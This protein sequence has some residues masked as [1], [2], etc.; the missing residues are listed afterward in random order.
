MLIE[1]KKTRELLNSTF[2]ASLNSQ[3]IGTS[4]DL[5]QVPKTYAVSTNPLPGIIIL[6]LGILMS[7]HHQTSMVSTMLHKQWGTLFV[8]AALARGVTYIL[9]YLSPPTSLLPSRPP[10]E[11][12]VAFCLISGGLLFMSSN[13][14]MVT[15]LEAHQ[16]NAMFIFTIIMAI[17][18]ALM[19]WT[20]ILLAVK[21]W[22]VRRTTYRCATSNHLA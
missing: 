5:W 10:S 14:D 7:S 11:L 20:I 4:L 17:T 19:A 16:L 18:S 12:V 1:S 3:D 15:A 8:G 21:A 22:A 9:V 13:A 2:T 6:L